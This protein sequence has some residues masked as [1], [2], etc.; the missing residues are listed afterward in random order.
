MTINDILVKARFLQKH[1]IEA[2][3]LKAIDFVPGDG[4]IIVYDTD[5]YYDY[6]RLK[7]GDGIS[8]INDLS[9]L[10][11]AIAEEVYDARIGYNGTVYDTLGEAIR[12][13]A[14]KINIEEAS[15]V[16]KNILA[17]KTW[18]ASFPENEL[19]T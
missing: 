19:I 2:N 6:P 14:V 9:F 11:G 10:D 15:V 1:D 4:E 3:W 8:A 16:G 7:I 13:Q 12:L 18:K 17:E 5:E